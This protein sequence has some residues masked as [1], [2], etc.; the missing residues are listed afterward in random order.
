MQLRPRKQPVQQR[1]RAVMEALV[2]A[3]ARV[4]AA[5]GYR[6]ATTKR[7]AEV[8]GVSVGSLYQYFPNKEA[9]VFAVAQRHFDDVLGRIAT[10]S[11]SPGVPLPAAVAGFVQAM[12]DAHQLEAEVHAAL[13]EQMLALGPEP[14]A[15][16][17]V[18]A[19][20]VVKGLLMAR[21]AEV[22]VGD[23]DTVAW[24]LA[25]TVESAVHRA[26]MEGPRR[27]GHPALAP[28]ITR[29]VCRYLRLEEDGGS[30]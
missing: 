5:D 30:P 27:L 28:E 25:T 4:L 29:L 17:Q 18:R 14:Y 10:V 16:T 7:I 13:T 26:L 12:I 15:E 6:G 24:L 23:L 8:A 11:F 3:T 1:S 22:D 21:R 2:E 9:L 20:A 19:I